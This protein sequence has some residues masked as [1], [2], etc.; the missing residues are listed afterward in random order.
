MHCNIGTRKVHHIGD[1]R[2]YV[3]MWFDKYGIANIF[4]L[5]K[6][7]REFLVLYKRDASNALIWAK[8]YKESYFYEGLTGL[9]YQKTR[10]GPP[11][12]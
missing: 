5:Y 2:S 7:K 9:Y 4:F 3:T 8:I 10:T 1:L 12:R 11:Y 6:V